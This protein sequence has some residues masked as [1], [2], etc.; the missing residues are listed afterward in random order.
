MKI[1]KLSCIKVNPKPHKSIIT[2]KNIYIIDFIY[3]ELSEISNK[4]KIKA[5]LLFYDIITCEFHEIPFN[6]YSSNSKNYIS[7]DDW[8]IFKK[9]YATKEDLDKLKHQLP[10]TTV[11]KV[12][13]VFG[14]AAVKALSKK[15]LVDKLKKIGELEEN[16][17]YEDWLNKKLASAI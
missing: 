14:E 15:K 9:Q 16:E 2:K 17:G 6:V 7:L 10:V 8:E 11:E 3:P 5:L 1:F 13:S 12:Y 4:R